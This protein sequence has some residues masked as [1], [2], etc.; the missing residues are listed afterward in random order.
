MGV[1]LRGCPEGVV[2]E[3]GDGRRRRSETGMR[4]YKL[5][6]IIT[7]V[8]FFLTEES[9]YSMTILWQNRYGVP[10]FMHTLFWA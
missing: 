10:V 7:L 1:E 9:I 6:H 8:F 4:K 3:N 5:T 2:T